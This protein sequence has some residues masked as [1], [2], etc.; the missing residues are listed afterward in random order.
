M[1]VIVV[2]LTA[3]GT[4]PQIGNA[5]D[6]IAPQV[7]DTA[8]VRGEELTLEG[9]VTFYFDQPMDR[10]SVEE[11]LKVNPAVSGTFE[12][13]NDSTAVFRPSSSLNRAT[14]YSFTIAE[15]AKS[16]TG[17]AL[18][19]TYS[20]KLRTL[21][22]L[23]VVQVLP[24]NNTKN[25][26]ATPTITVIFNR[27]VVP[28]L[29]IDEMAK[30]PSPIKIEPAAEGKG[31]WLNTS[32]YTFKPNPPL[33]GG[34]SYMVTV[35]KGL[36]DV[37]G[38]V[39]QNDY[40]FSFTTVAPRAIEIRP[41]DKATEVM[42]D[43]EIAVTFSQPM[44]TTATESAFSLMGPG[45]KSIPGT[46]KW[47]EGKFAF[48]FKPTGLLDYD[49]LY[50]VQ[51]DSTKA[52]SSTGAQ[53][54]KDA[55]ASFYTV[56][57]PDIV[58]TDPD[59]GV[60]ANP[61]GGFRVV[62]STPMN[63]KDFKS[64]V[65]ID[66]KPGLTYEDSF[67][68]DGRYYN[69]N[70]STEPSTSYTITID[71]NGLTDKYGTPLKLNPRSKVYTVLE[72]GKA[73]ITYQTDAYS[74]QASLRTGGTIG[75]Y[76]AYRPTTRVYATHRNISTLNLALWSIPVQD[77]LRL[78]GSNSY[79]F[80]RRYAPQD[81][82]RR[83]TVPVENPLNVL[84]YDLLTISGQG[85]SEGQVQNVTCIGAPPTRLK[86]GDRVVVLKDD[87]TPLRIR[88]APGLNSTI[89]AQVKPG[90]EFHITEGPICADKFLWWK[91]DSVDQTVV[92]WAAEGDPA[93]YF[94][95]PAESSDN[96]GKINPNG[97]TPTEQQ[98]QPT[99]N[100]SQTN[101]ANAPALKPGAYW[102]EF[103][104]PQLPDYARRIR[105]IMLV[106]TANVTL[107][108]SPKLATA[109]VTDLQSGQPVAGVNV[110]FYVSNGNPIG[111]PV[112]TDAN[113]IAQMQLRPQRDDGYIQDVFAVVNDGKNLGVG[114]ATWAD[115]INAY[116][117]NQSADYYAE[118]IT[119]YLYTD[120]S[121]YRPGQ[122]VYYKGVLRDRDD[123]TY[124][125]SSL[126]TVPVEIFDVEGKSVYKK[127][128]A[129]NQY[130][131]FSDSFNIDAN[132]P[133]GHYRI[134]VRPGFKPGDERARSFSRGFSVAQY[135]VPEFQV[136]VSPDQ[137]QVVQ[138]AKVKVTVDSTFFFG[139][140]VSNARVEWYV[141]GDNYFFNY[142][143]Q[144]YYNFYDFNDDEG[145]R[146]Y[147]EPSENLIANGEG[148]TDAQ[149]KFVIEVPADLGKAKQSQQL[150]VEAQVVDESGQVIAG[151][152]NVIV[153]QGEFYIGAGPENYVGTATKPQKVNLVTAEWDSKPKPN[154]DLSIRVVERQW[155][156]VQSVDP[157]SGR[158]VWN[159]DV[160]ET[161]VAE[162]VARTD[163][164]G[165]ATYE[166]TPPKGGIYKVY[167][168]SRD[169]R[170]NQITTSAFMWVA[171]PNYVPWR[172]Q[173]SN[174]ID[175]KIDRESY[176][177]G[178][179]ASILI[180]SPFQGETSALITVE[181]GGILKTEVL[182]LTNNS[183]IYQ[184]P[185]T[186][187]M[188][189]NAYFSVMIVKGVDDKNPVAAFRMGLVQ[190]GVETDRL[191][192]NISI[193]PDKP[194]AG[195]REKVNYAIK[196]TDFAG[197]PVK[198]EVGVGLTDLAVLSLLPDTSTPI[199]KHFYSEQGLSIRTSSTL[200]IS[201][202]QQ[203]QEIINTI[204]GGGGGG[205]EGGIFEVRQRF[206]DTPLWLPTV[207]T[208]EN[209]EATVEVTLPDQ[210]TTWRLDARAVTLP[211]GD[212][213]TTL[214]GQ[215]TFD[216]LSTKPLLIRPVTPRFYVVHDTSTL[217]AIVNNNTDADQDVKVRIDVKGVTLKANAEQTGKIVSR[218]RMRFEW[219]IEVLDVEAVDVTFFA[220]TA[221]NK[222]TD[223][224][225][226]AVGQGEDKTLPVL[227]Y[228]VPETVGTGGLIGKEGGDRVEGIVLPKRLN[229]Q[230]GTLKIRVEPSLAASTTS[231]LNVL[232]NFPYQ[233]IEQ[234]VSRFLPNVMTYRAF[235]QL[236]LIDAK[237]T[238]D[239]DQA[240]SYAVQRLYN[241]Q[242]SDGGWGWFINDKSDTLVTAYALIGLT[243][244]RDQGFAVDK[245]VIAQAISFLSKNLRNITD[246]A[247]A[248][249]LNR[250]SFL[251]Y[252][253]ARAGGGNFSRAVRLFEV[254]EKMSIYARAYLAMTFRMLDEKET[255]YTEPLM[256]DLQNRAIA[257][258]TGMHW[259]ESFE[260]RF[261][262]NS[263]TRT[264]ALVLKALVD[265]QPKNQLIPNVVRWLMIARKADA[266]ETTQETAWSVMALTDW[267]V[268]TGELKPNY[269]FDVAVNDKTLTSDKQASPETVRD[270]VQLQVA[271][272]DLLSDQVNKLTLNRTGGDGNLYYTA[273]LTAYLPVEE[274]KAAN[275]GIS[276]SRSYSL[277]D[278][279]QRKPIT[280][281]KVGDNI[282]VTLDIVAPN[283]L[284][285]IVI[286]DPI[287][288]GT[289]AVNPELATTGTVGQRPNLSLKDPLYRGWGWWW[290]SKTELR[291]DRVVLYAT[292]L[293]RG[294][295]QFTYTIRAGL[296]GEYR[297]IPS[298]G[299]EFYFPEV[300]GRSAGSLFTILPSTN[301]PTNQAT[302]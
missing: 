204:K 156:S 234:T 248:W 8:P 23:Q 131:S 203:T 287:P 249:T 114:S 56:K 17:A 299:Q 42:R 152:A 39:L 259:E 190:F 120:R 127:E 166:F 148:R 279:Q 262:W 46:F 163:A 3:L 162:G 97:N 22:A 106:G 58:R 165:K 137:E 6:A 294:T 146:E 76:S 145:Y 136:K 51:I 171:G 189:P 134:V 14:E 19:D 82:L 270:T 193:T 64:R 81:F 194:Q 177:I 160:K 60:K 86:V 260:D 104:S 236:G 293:P 7:I 266:W 296:A 218:G 135:R 101:P 216:I 47:N 62:F 230:D 87:P 61:Y 70:F 28:L 100:A 239:L 291:D 41:R 161:Q 181:R 202:D 44:N 191:K 53:I 52:L 123:V 72:G 117:F 232:K 78:S 122:P 16:K 121:L 229:I 109:W 130:G 75:L 277:M 271:V 12:W 103:S 192:L 105:H 201:V 300:Y 30:L 108:V 27:P 281:A 233:C 211:M 36:T 18:K 125:M 214:V 63:L 187:D 92:G 154:T 172:Q 48:T 57:L 269:T 215:T 240:V 2:A 180:A 268:V 267:M 197:T 157:E 292:Y 111:S 263:N 224:A 209:G 141:R 256:S 276:I 55:Q 159:W 118:N 80:E 265:I 184:L 20:L 21:G 67:D 32:I 143:G 196:V 251:L 132:A 179:T 295:Y 258:A 144:G 208:N 200:T 65:T 274:V 89:I 128:V 219:P 50:D 175:L 217:A 94:I 164:D 88:S 286:N 29:P 31:E 261:N 170:G 253:M 255:R 183:T 126:K 198:A 205:P 223:A 212:T 5:Q 113:G 91:L 110:Q 95:G 99:P 185:I 59:N 129:V 207:M 142:K 13:L 84:R 231:A 280:Q 245:G 206:V 297:V 246:Q 38:S 275:R 15:T 40:A 83:W 272:K 252:A 278:D 150:T 96:A 158:T 37:T 112:K 174:R 26:E 273:H 228:I 116:D 199:L 301:D 151:V 213:N 226:S 254:R 289:E 173:N 33:K 188:A 155:S 25:I 93:H 98:T 138:G 34:T 10:A 45:G 68:D 225:K 4:T 186:P 167:A 221:D 66:P 24:A 222:F 244:A 119:V 284:N 9:A 290:F 168:T 74:P 43:P 243:E 250:E 153:H 133:L 49:A 220:N 102:L 178:D 282:H 176:K 140:A 107:K 11:A 235:K 90:T 54:D 238:A 79:D 298:T 182:K 264:T 257:S 288:A 139:G 283:D 115:G 77:F 302:K 35:Q 247:Q 147:G 210:L 73:R 227:R 124:T 242:H 237:M 149:G 1:V 85:P 195:P 71:V 285:Y 241:E 69:V 169:S